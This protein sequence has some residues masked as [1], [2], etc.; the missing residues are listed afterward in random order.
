MVEESIAVVADLCEA[1]IQ[2]VL[3][4]QIVTLV[5]SHLSYF[6]LSRYV[7]PPFLNAS[8]TQQLSETISLLSSHYY[9]TIWLHI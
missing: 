6:H 7:L 9:I 2:Q 8:S 3:R 4:Y 5:Q 1:S